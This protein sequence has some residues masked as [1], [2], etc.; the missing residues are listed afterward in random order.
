VPRYSVWLKEMHPKSHGN[1]DLVAHFFR[2]TFDLLR[3]NGTLGLIATNTIAKGDTRASGLRWICNH[4][5]TIFTARKRLKWPGMASVIVSIIHIV[6][7]QFTKKKYLDGREVEKI[8]A[9]LFYR[10]GHEDPTPLAANDG[11]S[12]Q[13]CIPLGMGFTFD[14]TDTKGVASPIFE[15]KRLIAKNRNN[16]ECI[17]PFIG[18]SEVAN[19]PTHA[20]HR[21]IINFSEM[22]EEEARRWPDLM[23]IVEEKVKPERIKKN[24]VGAREKWWQ[25]LRPRP[26]LCSVIAS[27]TRVLVAG[28]Q[29][30]TH[31]AFAFLPQGL[32][33]SSNLSVIAV[34]TYAAFAV[35]QCPVHEI[36][37]R[38]F[39]ST[40]KD[41]LAYTP[42]TCFEPF[43]FPEN[44]ENHP[45]F[46]AAGK[47][48]YE[49]RAA[50]MVK[51]DEGL[52]KTYNRFHDPDERDPDILKLREL[53]SEMDRA[54]LDA[55]GWYNI[56]T[57]CE[58][59]LDYEIDEDEWGNKKKPWRYRWPDEVH[60]EV[61]ARLL[62][63]NVEL[64]R[65]EALAGGAVQKSKK[66]DDEK[67]E[68]TETELGG[69]F[70]L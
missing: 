38:F 68:D 69:L 29:A 36:W 61:L 43:P 63:L 12:F 26:E 30:S 44:W 64:A 70:S 7:G 60:D 49:F 40:R 1:A 59:L 46:E 34:E 3:E 42:T 10:G 19:N 35:L 54:V 11:K 50:L 39:M 62:E 67:P 37:S 32:V 53:H 16:A 14:D 9:F 5:G 33:Y 48:Y 20:P 21:Y 18:Y 51:N 55:Y 56:P 17:F 52:T 58:F 2:R 6:K 57:D 66:N 22:T 24:D 31:Y 27:L 47:A 23:K 8:T 15:M 45:A 4:N 41:D 65:E 28:S 13:G 25:F